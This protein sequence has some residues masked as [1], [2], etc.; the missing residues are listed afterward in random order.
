MTITVHR[1]TGGTFEY[2]QREDEPNVIE[3]RATYRGA[4]W[5]FV[6]RFKDADEARAALLEI[7][8]GTEEGDHER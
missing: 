5:S 1:P 4:R 3:S 6:A 2:R 8:K 7:G